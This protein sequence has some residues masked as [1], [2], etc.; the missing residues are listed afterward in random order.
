MSRR[1]PLKPHCLRHFFNW[2]CAHA[3][4]VDMILIKSLDIMYVQVSVN[5]SVSAAGNELG[6]RSFLC[7]PH[8]ILLCPRVEIVEVFVSVCSSQK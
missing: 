8:Y 2:N 5:R 6:V 7:C 1:H 4:Y 3:S